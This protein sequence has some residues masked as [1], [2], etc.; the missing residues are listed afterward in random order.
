MVEKGVLL[1]GSL[2]SEILFNRALLWLI[3][4]FVRATQ[5]TNNWMALLYLIPCAYNVWKSNETWGD[6]K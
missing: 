4:A 5:E 6:E 2:R 3:I 1:M